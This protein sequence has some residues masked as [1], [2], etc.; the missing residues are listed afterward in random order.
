MDFFRDQFWK[1]ICWGS[2]SENVVFEGAIFI[3]EN[4]NV[5]CWRKNF[6]HAFFEGAI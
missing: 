1:C 2:N 3:K 4:W 6:K 5:F